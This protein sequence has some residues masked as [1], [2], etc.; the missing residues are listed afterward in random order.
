MHTPHSFTDIMI[1]GHFTYFCHDH[2]FKNIEGITV[3]TDVLKYKTPFGIF[4][5]IFNSLVLKKHLYN[6]LE[7]R[8]LAIKISAEKK[9]F[10]K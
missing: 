8:N 1:E 6:F 9:P 10:T 3:M 4:G 5:R 7:K 2:F